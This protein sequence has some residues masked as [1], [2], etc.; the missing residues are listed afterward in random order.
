MALHFT[1]LRFFSLS[2][3]RILLRIPY[4]L[5]NAISQKAGRYQKQLLKTLEFIAFS[6]STRALRL[7]RRRY[8]S[9]VHVANDVKPFGICQAPAFNHPLKKVRVKIYIHHV[10]DCTVLSFIAPLDLRPVCPCFC[11]LYR[12]NVAVFYFVYLSSSYAW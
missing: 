6:L 3:Y 11:C 9:K 1:L 12:L 5:C 2:G 7:L 8:L 10:C 4:P